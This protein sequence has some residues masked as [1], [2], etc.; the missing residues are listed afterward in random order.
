MN[1]APLVS[2]MSLD[3]DA[4]IVASLLPNGGQPSR[5]RSPRIQVQSKTTDV[6][7]FVLTLADPVSKA[8]DESM[9]NALRV[10][11]ETEVPTLAIDRTLLHINT[12]TLIDNR[13]HDRLEK[14]SWWSSDLDKHPYHDDCDCGLNGCLKCELPITLHVKA[15]ATAQITH[16]TTLDLV[17]PPGTDLIPVDVK[18]W[19]ALHPA[20]VD[21]N[22]QPTPSSSS[23]VRNLHDS[24]SSSSP[25]LSSIPHLLDAW[26]KPMLLFKLG[27]SQEIKLTAYVRKGNGAMHAKWRPAWIN[28][29]NFRADIR[30]NTDVWHQK[31]THTQQNAF[32]ASCPTQVYR[33][34]SDDRGDRSGASLVSRLARLTR[35]KTPA[36]INT[37]V[38]VVASSSSS[39]SSKSR[40][41]KTMRRNNPATGSESSKRTSGTEM[42]PASLRNIVIEDANRCM[43]CKLCMRKAESFGVPELVSVDQTRPQQ[44][45]FVVQGKGVMP[46]E[47]IVRRALKLLRTRLDLQA[48][49]VQQWSLSQSVH[50]V[51]MTNSAMDPLPT[52]GPL[53][54]VRTET[55][56]S[57]VPARY[58]VAPA[59]AITSTSTKTTAM[60]TASTTTT[61]TVTSAVPNQV[62]PVQRTGR[63][64][65]A[66]P[67][68]PYRRIDIAPSSPAHDDDADDA[69]GDETD[70][71]DD[72]S[73][74]PGKR[75]TSTKHSST[76]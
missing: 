61:K 7:K 50:P 63:V 62:G 6:L 66:G 60:T 36:V 20:V 54:S 5:V 31:L 1:G 69:N 23:S 55:A 26:T 64:S 47:E 52:S 58:T 12:T 56:S 14:I 59:A 40:N 65:S 72:K 43:H 19:K 27:Q 70:E 3:R 33:L 57:S 48:L 25:D 45:M 76:S 11:M 53:V 32:V 49:A 37:P 51:W 74:V 18:R 16:V 39:S 46:P 30:L 73:R 4:Q 42:I 68:R 9:A 35:S 21:S 71:D 41:P 34:T 17:M 8:D 22:I 29:Y 44:F 24:T 2:Q 15:S 75:T 13:I 28:A 67:K 38:T 10:T